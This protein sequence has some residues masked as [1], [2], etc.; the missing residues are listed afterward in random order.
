MP[1]ASIRNR[2]LKTVRTP[3]GKSKIIIK[4]KKTNKHICA[5]SK[6]PLSGMPH[7]KRVF[8]VLRMSKTQRRPEN[9]LSS[10]L[11]SKV[12]DDVYLQAVMLKYNLITKDDVDYRYKKY[13]DMI[14]NK[15]E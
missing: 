14:Y 12:R 13:I 4:K 9:P 8:E 7:G 15:I 2:K 3:S 1:S 11:S 5:I 10:M 6:K